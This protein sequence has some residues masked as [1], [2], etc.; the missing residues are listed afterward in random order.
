MN[1]IENNKLEFSV[2]PKLKEQSTEYFKKIFKSEE[3]AYSLFVIFEK[4]INKLL[5]QIKTFAKEQNLSDLKKSIHS[6][7][8][9]LL[10]G[11][12]EKEGLF[13]TNIETILHTSSTNWETIEEEVNNIFILLTKC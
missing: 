3:K 11:G 8:G 13:V 12:L 1:N 6:L 9:V 5:N 10:N 4:N 7:K 2:T